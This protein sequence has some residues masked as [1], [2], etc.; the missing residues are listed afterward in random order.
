MDIGPLEYVVIGYEDDHFTNEILGS[1]RL[2]PC[3]RR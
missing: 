1:G 2:E 3:D